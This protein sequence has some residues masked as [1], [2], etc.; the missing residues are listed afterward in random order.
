MDK[1][2]DL[3]YQTTLPQRYNPKQW[4]GN[5]FQERS[6]IEEMYDRINALK[7]SLVIDAGCGKNQHK[8]FIKNLIGFDASPYPNVDMHCAI[9]DA[10]FEPNCADA[11]LALGSVQYISRDYVLKNIEKIISWV[12]PGGLIEMRVVFND[13]FS[14]AYHQIYDKDAVRFFWDDELREEIT[15]TYN[16]QY[17][18]E[19]WIYKATAPAGVLEKKYKKFTKRKIETGLKTEEDLAKIQYKDSLMQNLKRQCWTW[20]KQYE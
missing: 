13:D 3:Y 4:N 10:P 11:V 8:Y 9:Q 19:P 15:S 17:E 6:G 2:L 20:R 5:T 18:V 12:K 16:L 1:K 14:R 7:P